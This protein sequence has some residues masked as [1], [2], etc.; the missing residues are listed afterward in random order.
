MFSKILIANRGEIACR[1][2]QTAHRMG[3]RCVAVYSDADANARHVALADEAFR[4]GPAPSAESYLRGDLIIDI[5]KRSGAQ[6]IHPGY[7]FLSENAGFAEACEA[8]GLVFIGPPSSAIAAMGS[9][10]AAKSIMET[11]GVPLVPGY[12]GA[13]QSPDLLR[14][15]AEKCGFPLLLKAVAGGGGKGMRV[16]ERLAEFDDALAAAQREARNAFGNPDMLI[17]RYL[18]QPRH[19]EIQVFCDRHGNGIYLAER[20][21]SVQRRHQKVLEEA[22]APGL[23]E[24]VRQAMGEAAVRAAQAID[25][26]GAGTVEFLYDVDG[27]FFFMEMNTRL[28]VEHPVTEMVT[29]LDLVEWQLKVAWGEP[30]P[31]AQ[32]QVKTRGHALEARIYAED[33]DQDFLPAT[34]TLRYLRTPDESA[35]VRVDTGVTE[36]DEISIHYDP[37]IAKLI[38]WDETREQAINRM[39]QALE[40]YRIAGV[41]TNIR[42]LRALVDS[43]PFREAELTTHFIGQHESL[44]FPKARLDTDKALV[45][46]AAF[47]LEQRKSAEPVTADPWSPFGRKNS[48]RMNSE[49]AQPLK[50]QVGDDIH[51]LKILER[52]DRYL[53]LLGDSTYHL[54]A[55]LDDDYLQAVINGH[56]ISV[57]G[58][59]H[60]DDLVLF[61][62]G[63]TFKCSLYQE[64]YGFEE[65]ASEGSLAAPMNGA[66]VAIQ[67]KVGDSVSAGQTLV[68]MEAMKMEHAIK[69]PA[70]GV[71]TE[72]FFA[73]GDQVPEGAEL[74]AID[75]GEGA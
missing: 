15:E 24:E 35:H 36:G 19:V 57:H 3:I 68:I 48:W 71:V 17:E 56:R 31:L 73:E 16:V 49:Y 12:H 52:D 40:Q 33:P 18:T 66:V 4:L 30:L 50:L 8:H 27:S 61:H 42:F 11:A 58:H 69:A 72:I 2:I 5:A 51:E 22:P 23:S 28:Q 13:D 74:M 47:V 20:D 1:I 21:C 38:V 55:R 70:D 26:V 10:S 63:D 60:D 59:L 67:V 65:L 6:A 29:G 25:Y 34:G 54:N 45:L 43:Q 9:K 46:A 37:M 41:R 39:V 75:T 62:E 53:V 64:T 44:L 14:A 32:A 7:G